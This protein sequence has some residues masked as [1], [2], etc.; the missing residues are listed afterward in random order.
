MIQ[1]REGSMRVGRCFGF[2][3]MVS[4]SIKT[5]IIQR[6]SPCWVDRLDLTDERKGQIYNVKW[7]WGLRDQ[8]PGAFTYVTF[9][10][11]RPD[12]GCQNQLVV[13][14]PIALRHIRAGT[15]VSI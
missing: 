15:L 11:T 2:Q 5:P 14:S 13:W 10:L 8:R 6:S 7:K 3:S 9:S 1:R 12:R 4:S